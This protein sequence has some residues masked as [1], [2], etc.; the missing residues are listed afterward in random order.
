MSAGKGRMS[1]PLWDLAGDLIGLSQ[2][3]HWNGPEAIGAIAVLWALLL[4]YSETRR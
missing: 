1:F 2:L 3:L 4:L